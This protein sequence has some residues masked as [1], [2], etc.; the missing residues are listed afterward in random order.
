MIAASMGQGP[1]GGEPF[2]T[3]NVNRGVRFA[4]RTGFFTAMVADP[5]TDRGERVIRFDGPVSIVVAFLADQGHIAL[6]PLV[7]RTGRPARGD[8][9][10][11]DG[12][13]VGNGLRVGFVDRP[14]FR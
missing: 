7:D 11:F 5:P 13:G 3:H 6:R 2:Q 10:L 12:I 14:S 9:Q 1:V 4:P 8:A